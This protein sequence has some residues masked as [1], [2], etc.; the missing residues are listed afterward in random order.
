M[1]DASFKVVLADANWRH[2]LLEGLAS[3]DVGRVTVE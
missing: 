1:Y 2:L 3:W